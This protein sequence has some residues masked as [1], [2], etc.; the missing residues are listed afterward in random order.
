MFV[1]LLEDET[2]GTRDNTEADVLAQTS[3]GDSPSLDEMNNQTGNGE[4]LKRKIYNISCRGSKLE[5]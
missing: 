5:R 3:E 2:P 1:F 4:I